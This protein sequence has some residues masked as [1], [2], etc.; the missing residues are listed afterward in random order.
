M[1]RSRVGGANPVVRHTLIPISVSSANTPVAPGIGLISPRSTALAYA[2][3]N[4]SFARV[5]LISF[6]PNR[7]RN[8][9]IFDWPIEARTWSSAASICALPSSTPF[10]TIASTKEA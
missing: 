4:E 10:S 9:A 2:A 3:S 6:P 5:A 7:C 8:T 1:M